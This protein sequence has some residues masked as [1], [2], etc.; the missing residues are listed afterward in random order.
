MY[1]YILR[2]T[3][4]LLVFLFSTLLVSLVEFKNPSIHDVKIDVDWFEPELI[5]IGP[6]GCDF[7]QINPKSF[8]RKAKRKK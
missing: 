8:P 3:T 4:F 5:Y 1:R 7:E 6:G 2:L